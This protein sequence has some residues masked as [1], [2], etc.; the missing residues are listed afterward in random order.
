MGSN[1]SAGTKEIKILIM[2]DSIMKT[3]LWLVGFFTTLCAFVFIGGVF[4]SFLWNYCIPTIF[5][6]P[7]ITYLQAVALLAVIRIL[8]PNINLEEKH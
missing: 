8:L 6:L 2:L 5:G 3:V 4:L 7:E 1:P